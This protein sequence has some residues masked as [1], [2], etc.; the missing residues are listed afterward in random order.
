[1]NHSNVLFILKYFTLNNKSK[2][3]EDMIRGQKKS[4]IVLYV[5]LWAILFAAAALGVYWDGLEPSPGEVLP[6]V[7]SKSS[8]YPDFITLVVPSYGA[9]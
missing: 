9:Q 8:S 5:V 1:M 6:G 4:E 7:S 2:G 3:L